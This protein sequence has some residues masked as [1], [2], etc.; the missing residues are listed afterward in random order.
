MICSTLAPVQGVCLLKTQV[1]EG[2]QSAIGTTPCSGRP[3]VVLYCLFVRF[4]FRL[5]D[6]VN[7]TLETDLLRSERNSTLDNVLQA[8]HVPPLVTH[9]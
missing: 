6:E 1:A 2:K 3:I 8:I 7:C 4:L 9:L 5:L